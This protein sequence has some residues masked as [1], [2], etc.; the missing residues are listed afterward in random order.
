M[1]TL[2]VLFALAWSPVGAEG[3]VERKA[4]EIIVVHHSDTPSG[5]VAA[6]RRHH[7]LVNGWSDVGY[8]FV[9]CNGKGGADGEVQVGRDEKY[10]GAHAGNPKPS[11]NANSIGVCLVGEDTFT[12]AQ[13]EALVALLTRLCKKYKITPSAATVQRHHEKCPGSG[14]NMEDIIARCRKE[15]EEKKK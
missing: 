13:R 2:V 7:V 10:Q 5:N 14:L 6:F 8:H 15:C 4:T 9:V 1:E 3:M 11:R 12:E